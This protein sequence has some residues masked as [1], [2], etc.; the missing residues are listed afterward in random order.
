MLSLQR[1]EGASKTWIVA[2]RQGASYDGGA[3]GITATGCAVC[4][5]S[6][7]AA[8]LDLDTGLVK[9]VFPPAVRG[10]VRARWG[11]SAASMAWSQTLTPPPSLPPIL[12]R[13]TTLTL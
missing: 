8:L 7:H 1:R 12:F 2:R 6:G 5:V 13:A 9:R 3:V 11:C 4:A 10:G